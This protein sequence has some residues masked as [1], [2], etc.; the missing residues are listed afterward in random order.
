MS[1]YRFYKMIADGILYVIKRVILILLDIFDV[2]FLIR[3]ILSWIDPMDE[4]T[5]SRILFAVTE[6]LIIP[7]RRLCERFHWFQGLPLD[8]PFMLTLLMMILVRSLLTTF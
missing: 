7:I 5:V 1:R 3:A 8:M 2:A 6:P 4:F